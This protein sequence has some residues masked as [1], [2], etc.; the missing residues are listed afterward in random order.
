MTDFDAG[1]IYDERDLFLVAMDV[2]GTLTPEAWLALQE[3]T[4]LEELKLTTAHEPDYDKLMKYRIDVLR[5]NNIKLQDM[6]DVV[7]DLEPLA[8][9]REFLEW[10]K[11]IV[12][13][14]LLLT[15]TFEE[16]AMPMF[17]KLGYPAVFCNSLTVDPDG[18]ITGHTLR[19]KDQKRRAVEAFQR[20]NFRVIAI[21]DSFNDISMLKTSEHGILYCPGDRVMK[22]HPE[23]PVVRSHDELRVKVGRIIGA[24][25]RVMPRELAPI[26]PLGES[27]ASRS[28]WLLICNVASTLAPEPWPAVQQALN[29]DELKATTANEP[30]FT[31]LMKHRAAVLRKH[32]VK[33]QDVKNIVEKLT[34]LP[35]AKE[36]LEWLKPILP[37]TFMLTDG[38]EEYA[39]PIFDKLGHPMVFCNFVEADAEGYLAKH[40]VRTK[41]Q[42]LKAVQEFQRLN[43]RIIAVGHS[44]NDISMLQAAERGILYSPSEHVIKANPGIPIVKSHA[45]LKAHILDILEMGPDGKRRKVA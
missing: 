45:E 11:P 5:K 34:P 30:D 44:L 28:M 38:F 16:Y 43:F 27:E 8:G 31:K 14:V 33:L 13:R 37:R 19:L 39:L 21:G 20:M 32:G 9:A 7:Q 23:F 15:D 1:D 29:I 6:R 36:F 25:R 35:G 26:A 17:E 40:I 42:K 22:A 24:N 41:D 3:K 18:T 10:L 2:E 4:G 12:P